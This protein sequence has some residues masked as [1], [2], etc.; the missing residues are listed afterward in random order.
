MSDASEA[1]FD[2][3]GGVTGVTKII[4]EMYRRV[5]EDGLLSPFFEGVPMD[6]LRSMQYHFFASALDGP[7]TYTGAELNSIHHGRGITAVHF[8]KFCGHFADA[9]EHQGASRRDVDDALAR[10]ATYRDKITGDSNIDG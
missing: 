6:R 4:D 3:L 2:R 9:M 8:A 7:S 10:L 5:L 1:L